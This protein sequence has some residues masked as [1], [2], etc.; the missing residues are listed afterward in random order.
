MLVVPRLSCHRSYL[1]ET[2]TSSNQIT[3]L[4]SNFAGKIKSWYA[5]H[6]RHTL[7][8]FT[9][10]AYAFLFLSLHPECAGHFPISEALLELCSLA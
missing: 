2:Q 6:A 9:F 3:R 4:Q 7:T 10:Q 1:Y 8:P 5:F